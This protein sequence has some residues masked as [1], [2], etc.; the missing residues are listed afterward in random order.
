MSM[1]SSVERS[2]APPASTRSRIGRLHF[3]FLPAIL[4]LVVFYILPLAALFRTSFF[5]PG[6][7]LKYYV[8]AFT[9]SIYLNVLFNT[10]QISLLVTILCVVIAYPLA[11]FLTTL[12][13]RSRNLV[14]IGV[15]L[16]YFTSV[17]V[18]SYAWLIILGREGAINGTLRWLGIL[19][20][21]LVLVYNLTGVII[22]MTHIL[23][24]VMVLSLY[25]VM[26][27]INKDMIAVSQNSSG[28]HP[29][30]TFFRVYLPACRASAPVAFSSSS[31]RSGIT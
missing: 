1:A 6:F 17:L 20:H 30:Q 18:R 25:G 26:H 21:P 31:L 5:D 14:L 2:G 10:L 13:E 29:V 27:N 12:S 28:A 24:P 4:Y 8:A 22:G 15:V 23:L 7:T 3:L 9:S 16:P 11:Y 19:D